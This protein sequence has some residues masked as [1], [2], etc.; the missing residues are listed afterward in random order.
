M[1]FSDLSPTLTA[2]LLAATALSVTGLYFLRRR[3][4]AY[5]VSNLD[6]WRA[7]LARSKPRTLFYLRIPWL[8]FLTSALIALLLAVLVAGPHFGTQL[9]GPT[10]LV[11]SADRTMAASDNAVSRIDQAAREATDWMGRASRQGSFVVIRAGIR[12]TVLVGQTRDANR[13]REALATIKPDDGPADLQAAVELAERILSKHDNDGQILLFSDRPL[14]PGRRQ[15]PLTFM[16]IGGKADTF[17]ISAFTARRDPTAAGEYLAEV[18]I[19]SFAKT[20]G[21]GRVT[22]KDR[23]VTIFD[24]RFELGPGLRIRMKATGFGSAHGE[25]HAR[26]SEVAIQGSKDAHERDDHAFASVPSMRATEVLVVTEGSRWVRAALSVH[27]LLRTTV[28]TPGLLA[29]NRAD[30]AKYDV[31]ILD[32][33]TPN[34]PLAHP[35]ILAFE[36]D[37]AQGVDT[38]KRK[39]APTISATLSSHPAMGRVHLER[40]RVTRANV[41]DARPDDQVLLRS[42]G[43][44]LAVARIDSNGRLVAFGF[45]EHT[46][47]IGVHAVFPLMLHHALLWLRGD[48]IHSPNARAPGQALDARGTV[49]GPDG[50]PVSVV[51]GRVL[52]TT[53]AGLYQ[54]ESQTVPFSAAAHSGLLPAPQ[55]R[56][57]PPGTESLPPLSMMLGVLALALLLLEWFLLQRGILA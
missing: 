43:D 13:S 29:S 33:V 27:P 40:V 44:P 34:P 45:S 41:L 7:A 49:L 21:T 54:N 55:P 5:L 42:G 32:R 11:V 10:V 38:V 1:G 26:L 30:V 16:P 8:A 15:V 37:G 51:A 17:A 28:W 19:A 3:P 4:R 57:K 48:A 6:F 24:Q 9:S 50:E 31:V 2:A 39:D 23:D 52:D 18:E 14:A 47:D 20:Q 53:Q 56:A 22:V 46:S 36:A 25:L 35:G 12:P